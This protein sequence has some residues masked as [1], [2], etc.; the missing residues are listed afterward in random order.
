MRAEELRLR[1]EN[2]VRQ[3]V[4]IAER[5]RQNLERVLW[6]QRDEN[7]E[8]SSRPT[9]D[10][11][12]K[13]ETPTTSPLLCSASPNRERAREIARVAIS[14]PPSE[15]D[16]LERLESGQPLAFA[17]RTIPLDLQDIDEVQIRRYLGDY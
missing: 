15:A 2:E 6:L 17:A 9:R 3:S 13:P 8:A 11:A 4:A 14:S 5:I 12:D 7:L 10:Q 1:E 16:L